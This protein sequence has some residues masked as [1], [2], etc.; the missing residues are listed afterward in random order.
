MLHLTAVKCGV[1]IQ[2]HELPISLAP[3]SISKS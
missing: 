2:S 3:I 1:L